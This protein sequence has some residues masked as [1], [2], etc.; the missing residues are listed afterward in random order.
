[1]L[2]SVYQVFIFIVEMASSSTAEA[3]IHDNDVEEVFDEHDKV[4]FLDTGS[5]IRGL[6]NCHR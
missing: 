1:M 5:I 4:D 2:L 6:I 3:I